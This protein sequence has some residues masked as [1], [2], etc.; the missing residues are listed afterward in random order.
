MSTQCP[1]TN[2]TII[3]ASVCQIEYCRYIRERDTS[4]RRL[5]E[6]C[7]TAICFY[8][9]FPNGNIQIDFCRDAGEV[10]SGLVAEDTDEGLLWLGPNSRIYTGQPSHAM[11]HTIAAMERRSVSDRWK[12][13]TT[14]LERGKTR[15][16]PGQVLASR[17]IFGGPLH[18]RPIPWNVRLSPTSWFQ[19]SSRRVHRHG[20]W[21]LRL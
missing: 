9:A 5:Y 6:W 10:E 2:K 19:G 3:N 18:N 17:L 15:P 16:M 13:M 21:P 8:G 4:R 14:A 12:V 1:A 20:R 11:P 7:K